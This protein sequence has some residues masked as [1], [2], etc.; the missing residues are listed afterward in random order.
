M[1]NFRS[2]LVYLVLA[3]LLGGYI[4][5][6]ERGPV[7]KEPLKNPK[8]FDNFVADDVREIKIENLGTTLT[9]ERVP[10]DIQK[11][12]KDAW[13][14]VSPRQFKGDETT[15]RSLLTTVGQFNPDTTIDNPPHLSDYGLEKPRG[16]CT[17]VDKSGKSMVLWIGDK[18]V[19]G[20]FSY[21]KT[22]D[23][24]R[25]Y[26]LP[27]YSSDTLLKGLN[28][29]RDHT[30]IHTDTVLAQKV[31]VM[32]D[33]KSVVLV[34][35]K[36]N[37]WAIAEPIQDKADA[38]KVR[39]LLN[40]IDNLRVDQF[41]EDHPAHLNVYGLT[42]PH[43]EVEV[44][45]SDGGPSRAILL[46][47]KKL[48]V[49]GYFAKDRDQ[50]VVSLVGGYFE[51][52]LSVN[53][54]DYRDKTLLQFDGGAVKKLSVTHNGRT[55]AYQKDGK[56]QWVSEGRPNAQAEASGLVNQLA[57][58]TIGEFVGKGADTGLAVPAFTVDVALTDGTQRV[59]RFGKR[60]K[61]QVYLASDKS[62]EAYLVP[63]G[64]LSEMEVDFNSIL[65]PVPVLSPA[66]APKK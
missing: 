44:W 2:T 35:D 12:A 14:I 15:L 11:D 10:I 50:P 23:K 32:K 55:F 64:V 27:S 60:N 33:G 51:S 29:L 52:S 7:K 54:S 49:N 38:A 30:F 43:A 48:K 8:V 47:R 42:A 36:N 37:A 21:F 34:K 3:A 61:N 24:N 20:S 18:T 46:G 53:P 63:A 57:G 31:R 22:P 45:P 6:F 62:K 41:V 66:P 13:Q 59:F 4:Y 58:M 40:S 28:D 1:K 17:F 56:G 26:L 25:V 16:R 65:T 9:A 5:F 19:D 39:D